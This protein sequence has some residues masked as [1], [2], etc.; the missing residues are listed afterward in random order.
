MILAILLCYLYNAPLPSIKFRPLWLPSWISEWKDFSNF[1]SISLW[2]FPSSF[3]SI[4]LTVW[5]EIFE[6]WMVAILYIGTERFLQFWISMSPR[7]LPSSF[8]SIRLM[9]WEMSFEEFQDGR[10]YGSHLGY[11]NGT[12]LAIL[13]TCVIVMPPIKFWPNPTYSLGGDVAWRIS[14]WPP[15][16][17]W[18]WERYDFSNS[19]SLCHF[20]ASHQVLAQSNL[21]FGRRCRLK[22]LGYQIG[23]ILAILN[24]H[25]ATMSSTKFQLNPTYGSGGD[26]E[27]V[28]S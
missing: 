20:D 23:T 14:R 7:L 22:N 17:S 12:I 15:W 5:E 10:C 16:P 19:E 2:C 8:G 4:Q 21:G 9:V 1:E 24:L 18:I 6:E 3:G 11:W 25:V 27:N 28:Q 13:N 26:I